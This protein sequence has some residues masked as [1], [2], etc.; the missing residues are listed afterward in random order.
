MVDFAIGWLA[1]RRALS[2]RDA[3][4]SGQRTRVLSWQVRPFSPPR[5]AKSGGS[6]ANESHSLSVNSA[7]ICLGRLRDETRTQFREG[8]YPLARWIAQCGSLR[9]QQVVASVQTIAIALVDQRLGL[10]DA[11]GQLAMIDQ[12][13]GQGGKRI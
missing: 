11:L 1:R 6:K 5:I 10:L 7:P 12:N 9:E 8:S 3:A 2:E 13:A 4:Q